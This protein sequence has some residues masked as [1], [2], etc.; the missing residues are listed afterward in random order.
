MYN[1]SLGLSGFRT[2]RNSPVVT[3]AERRKTDPVIF[4]LTLML[5][6]KPAAIALI[7]TTL[8]CFAARTAR[9]QPAGEFHL[10]GTVR[11][12]SGAPVPGAQVTLTGGQ[13][14]ATQATNQEGRFRFDR[15]PEAARRA[16]ESYVSSL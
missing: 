6:S 4:H 12:A 11:D 5:I 15:L 13:F 1:A 10:E 7:V 9:S 14:H 8:F 2:I 3:F 16:I